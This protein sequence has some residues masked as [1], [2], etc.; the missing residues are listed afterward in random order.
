MILK[1]KNKI[2]REMVNGDSNENGI[3][4]NRSN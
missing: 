3:K 2:N 1:Q 4:I